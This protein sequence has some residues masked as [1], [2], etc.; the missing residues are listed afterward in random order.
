LKIIKVYPPFLLSL[1][2]VVAGIENAIE[3]RI[4]AGWQLWIFP[5][6]VLSI[7]YFFSENKPLIIKKQGVFFFLLLVTAI[8]SSLFG[9]LFI[10]YPPLS[11]ILIRQIVSHEARIIV[12]IIRFVVCIFGILLMLHYSKIYPSWPKKG[13]LTF[14]KGGSLVAI[15]GLY[16]FILS[17]L[18][19]KLYLLPGSWGTISTVRSASLFYE[20][21]Q[22]GFFCVVLL[23]L[24]MWMSDLNMLTRKQ[25]ILFPLVFILGLCT[26]VSGSGLYS[27]ILGITAG[28][29]VSYS[30]F[31]K[32]LKLTILV[33]IPVAVVLWP[34]IVTFEKYSLAWKHKYY[35]AI[36]YDYFDSAQSRVYS[37][38][39][40]WDRFLDVNPIMGA[41]LGTNLFY[42]SGQKFYDKYLFEFG[43]IGII[44]I[45][46]FAFTVMVKIIRFRKNEK[47]YFGHHVAITICF[48]SGLF[49]YSAIEHF[50]VWYIF[51][52]LIFGLYHPS[53]YVNIVRT[54][55]IIR[56][57]NT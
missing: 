37:Q 50:W 57:Y 30:Y 45:I 15:Y 3:V 32:W 18:D 14:L 52:I 8:T 10:D 48:F 4:W 28:S 49:N 25:K 41:G 13:L 12:S 1:A 39:S 19:I 29:L 6:V 44:L 7:Y 5:L 26:S 42:I 9:L 46:V 11:E 23:L 54:R 22:F 21:S 47:Q 53:F 56:T 2:L 38:I 51:F 33:I 43:L 34:Y 27:L 24:S 16:E 55:N 35:Q 20:P 36:K 31:K 40:S 17:L